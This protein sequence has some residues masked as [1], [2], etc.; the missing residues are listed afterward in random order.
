MLTI[1]TGVLSIFSLALTMLL[2]IWLLE[3]LEQHQIPQEQEPERVRAG[4]DSG[5][6]ADGEARMSMRRLR[7]PLVL[8]LAFATPP[9]QAGSSLALFTDSKAAAANTF[10]AGT[11]AFYLHNN[12]TPPTANTTSQVNLAMNATVPTAATLYQYST[13]CAARAGRRLT[14]A[15]P[16]PTQ[17]T[18]CDYVNWRT[19]AVTAAM[20]LSGTVKIGHLGH[21]RHANREPHRSAGRLLARLQPDGRRLCPDRQ[22][23]GHLCVP[24][25]SHHLLPERAITATITGTYTLVAGHELEVKVEASNAGQNNMLVAYDTAAY[26]SYLRIR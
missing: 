1:P 10:S 23:H 16:S 24:R 11:W 18:V 17:A 25:G 12:P 2:C 22:R 9:A 13:D 19:A 4:E 6:V 21:D 8:M 15:A 5:R 7:V 26:P 14:L 3:D 20:T